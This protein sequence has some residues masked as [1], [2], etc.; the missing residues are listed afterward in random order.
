M[1]NQIEPSWAN[2]I[3]MDG[4]GSEFF[5]EKK[6]IL[7]NNR[8]RSKGRRML[9]DGSL[10]DPK[11]YRNSLRFTEKTEEKILNYTSFVFKPENKDRFDRLYEWIKSAIAD[12]K[13]D[14]KNLTHIE[15]E[16][17]TAEYIID[18]HYQEIII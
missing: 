13:I 17:L 1:N 15:V 12:R 16:D 14:L 7:V 6:P 2:Y 10:N 3:A 11:E 4:D 8:W 18:E 5:Y 9:I